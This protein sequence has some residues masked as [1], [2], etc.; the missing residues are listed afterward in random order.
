MGKDMEIKKFSYRRD[1]FYPFGA[2]FFIAICGICSIL[3]AQN[4]EI[5]PLRNGFFGSTFIDTT[6][7]VYGDF[8]VIYK[9]SDLGKTWKLDLIGANKKISQ[10]EIFNDTLW[11][12]LEDS[13]IICSTNQGKS[14]EIFDIKM[15]TKEHFYWFLVDS[16]YFYIRCDSTI[17]KV[18]RNF[19]IIKFL[20]DTIIKTYSANF[21]STSLINKSIIITYPKKM[22]FVF[23]KIVLPISKILDSFCILDKNFDSLKL[24]SIKDNIPKQEGETSFSLIDIFNFDNKF[25][26]QFF[27]RYTLFVTD[28]TFENWNLFFKDSS[29][30]NFTFE[31]SLK[32]WQNYYRILGS[33]LFTDKDSLYGIHSEFAKH[34]IPDGSGGYKFLYFNYYVKKYRSEPYDTLIVIGKPFKDIYFST[35]IYYVFGSRLGGEIISE[36]LGFPNVSFNKDIVVFTENNPNNFIT[37]S[38]LILLTNSKF[39]NWNLVNLLLGKPFYILN[40]STYF[41]VKDIEIYRTFDGGITFK[42]FETYIEGDTDSYVPGFNNLKEIRQIYIDSTGKGVLLGIPKN[43]FPT[44][45]YNFFKNIEHKVSIPYNKSIR[46]LPNSLPSNI[47]YIDDKFL[48]SFFDTSRMKFRYQ[49]Y[50]GDSSFHSF[51][52]VVFDSMWAPIYLVP[53]SVNEFLAVGLANHSDTVTFEIRSTNDTGHTWLNLVRLD[54]LIDI[55][56]IYEHNKDSIFVVFK[57]PDRIYLYERPTNRLQLVWQTENN[58]YAPMLMVISDR[59][60][61][62]GR[63]LFLENTDRSD[64]TKW[65]E[66]EWDYGKPNFES[67]IFKGNVAIAGLSDSLRPFN[68]YKITL[69]KQTPSVV[70]EQLDKRYYTTKFWASEPYPQPAE[71]RVK[72]R[73]AWDG[74][75]DVSEAIDGVY[76]SMGRKVEGKERIRVT[77]RDKGYGELEWECSGVPSGVYFILLRWA[78]GSE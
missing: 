61:I 51:N 27:P 28:S 10:L 22:Y 3:K 68:Y 7:F 53:L 66:G 12:I 37:Q 38:K 42:P 72:A 20:S 30:L 9:S 67:V 2:I 58:S 73:F 23:N 64:L 49:I 14:W 41:F 39:S 52:L 16:S 15:P 43:P 45:T 33:S 74:S 34:Y 21:V 76:D 50:V 62:V 18:D 8:G 35:H 65:R 46:S 57:N 25:C 32:R 11:G 19:N 31:D 26:F 59:F 70:D 60:Y 36:Q 5:I 77:L 54:G 1:K 75:F 6:I 47:S 78:G 24:I 40:D 44:K 69:K 63:G 4:F 17:L 71:V 56:Q 48:F 13:H 29:F 55:N